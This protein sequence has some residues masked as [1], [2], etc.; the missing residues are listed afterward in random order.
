[1]C[2]HILRLRI[3]IVFKGNNLLIPKSEISTFHMYRTL[4]SHHFHNKH[5][6]IIFYK[7]KTVTKYLYWTLFMLNY[8]HDRFDAACI[9]IMIFLAKRTYTHTCF[10]TR[11]NIFRYMPQH[12]CHRNRY[13][14]A[15]HKRKYQNLQYFE[16]YSWPVLANQRQRNI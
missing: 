1:L 14:D 4:F 6:K 9:T 16:D 7:Q 11:N 10:L 8:L 15:F 2:K 13:F 12:I 3:Y 5:V